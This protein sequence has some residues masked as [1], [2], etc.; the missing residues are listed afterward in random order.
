[1]FYIYEGFVDPERDILRGLLGLLAW[2]G[3]SRRI[4]LHISSM[5]F[6][7][8]FVLLFLNPF[9]ISLSFVSFRWTRLE[10]PF[11]KER[12]KSEESLSE[13]YDACPSHVWSDRTHI[14]HGAV[15]VSPSNCL[16]I[17]TVHV[18][19][20]SR[21]EELESYALRRDTGGSN[22]ETKLHTETWERI[23]KTEE[24]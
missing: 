11:A 3:G 1:M 23:R 21:Y 16:R 17:I 18:E 19:S 13:R 8:F 10:R 22:E 20:Q 7:P 4:T 15:S 12:K 24:I 2:C 14:Y 9:F 5:S 6:V